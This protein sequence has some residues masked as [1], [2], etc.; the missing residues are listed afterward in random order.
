MAPQIFVSPPGVAPPY[1]FYINTNVVYTAKDPSGNERKCSFRVLLE[2]A[3]I[4]IER[5]LAFD[6]WTRFGLVASHVL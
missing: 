1:T 6:I 5:H 4:I 2:G 3:L